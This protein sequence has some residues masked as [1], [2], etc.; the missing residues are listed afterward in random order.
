MLDK[1]KQKNICTKLQITKEKK[2]SAIY[3]KGV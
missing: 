1:R 2:E 3:I